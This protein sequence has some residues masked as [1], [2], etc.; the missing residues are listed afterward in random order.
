MPPLDEIPYCLVADRKL[1]SDPTW[2]D[3]CVKFFKGRPM[4][5]LQKLCRHNHCFAPWSLH[6]KEFP[7]FLTAP[8]L[9][10]QSQETALAGQPS[11]SLG[12]PSAF[13]SLHCAHTDLQNTV[14]YSG[15]TFQLL[16]SKLGFRIKRG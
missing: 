4:Q 14:P 7:A 10:L 2:T 6:I 15:S 5:W 11:L 12:S 3:R 9:T 8:Q 13:L 16:Y 1:N